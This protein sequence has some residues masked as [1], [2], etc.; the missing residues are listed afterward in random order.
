MKK[1]VIGFTGLPGSGKS[2]AIAGV[3]DLGVSISMGDVIR[4][5]SKKRNLE[6]TDENLGRTARDLRAMGGHKIIA[7]KCVDFINELDSDAIYID[8]IRSY[9]EVTVFR[10]IWKFPLIA[11]EASENI[12]FER[13][14]KRGRHDDPKVIDDLRERDNREIGFGVKDAIEK[15]D[16]KFNNDN[17]TI[18]ALQNKVRNLVLE[19]LNDK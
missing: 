2:V 8:G 18:K 9:L 19:I 7:E 10:E 15:A 6:P 5:E 12:R 1:E 3:E 16:Y 13:L 14:K 4:N 11:I 17:L